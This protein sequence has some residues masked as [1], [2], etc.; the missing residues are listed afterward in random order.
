MPHVDAG[1]RCGNGMNACVQDGSLQDNA[2]TKTLSGVPQSPGAP[3]PPPHND[4]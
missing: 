4:H 3:P 1:L 2:A